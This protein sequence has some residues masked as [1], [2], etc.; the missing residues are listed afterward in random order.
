MAQA[1][2]RK[3]KTRWW[4]AYAARIGQEVG[5]FALAVA[6]IY[7]LLSLFS[8]HYADPAWSYAT[9][10]R[11]IANMG[12]VVGAWFADLAL[13]L[14]GYFAFVLPLSLVYFGWMALHRAPGAER[15]DWPFWLLRATGLLLFLLA[16]ID[17]E[18]HGGKRTAGQQKQQ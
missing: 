5:L 8:Y 6:A 11:R 15:P 2:V 3:P 16:G 7:L 17:T 12:G 4:T 13:Y 1:K 18:M 10:D 14:L 9:S